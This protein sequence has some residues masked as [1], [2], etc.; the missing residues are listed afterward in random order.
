VTPIVRVQQNTLKNKGEGLGESKNLAWQLEFVASDVNNSRRK[1]IQQTSSNAGIC[2]YKFTR[3]PPWSAGQAFCLEIQRTG[4][5]FRRYDI[6]LE[7]VGPERGPLS[8]VS[9]TEEL[10]EMREY[11]RRDPSHRQRDTPLAAK[12]G[13]NFADNRQSLGRYSSL[14]HSDHEV[15][16]FL[17][18]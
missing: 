8:L 9:T 5:D 6:S 7:L 11:G 17:I 18:A 14:V 12:V 13:T 16:L 1:R 4:F 3:P 10:L 2:H 15:R